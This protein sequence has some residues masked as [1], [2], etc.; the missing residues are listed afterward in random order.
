MVQLKIKLTNFK[1]LD[2]LIG[3]LNFAS[4]FGPLK[5]ITLTKNLQEE[6]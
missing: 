1:K 5:V 4:K 2:I 3:R 6:D